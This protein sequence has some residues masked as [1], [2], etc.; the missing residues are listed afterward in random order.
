MTTI[1]LQ[2]S[3]AR[4]RLYSMALVKW[5]VAR[6]F[7]VTV[8]ELE[9]HDRGTHK[10]TA[11][12]VAQALAYVPGRRSFNEVGKSFEG[13]D[14]TTVMNAVERIRARVGTDAALAARVERCKRVCARV[15]AVRSHY[16][17]LMAN[18]RHG[19]CELAVDGRDEAAAA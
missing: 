7:K 15:Q 18:H 1:D 2:D 16:E 17:D 6:E 5:V 14:H 10:T 11:R 9:S 19:Q 12:Q 3:D 8:E 13:R 4:T